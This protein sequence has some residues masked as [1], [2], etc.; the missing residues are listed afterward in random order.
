MAKI[1][2]QIPEPAETYDPSNQR[3]IKQSLDTIKN[4]LNFSFQEE[5]KQEVERFTWFNLRFGC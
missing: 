1:I 3:Q 5:L 4:E 2:T